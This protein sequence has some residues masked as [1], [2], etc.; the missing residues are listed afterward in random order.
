M[1]FYQL[2]YFQKVSETNS[3]SRAAE[4]LLI[5]QPAVT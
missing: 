3:I 5:T 1:N 2:T 4:K